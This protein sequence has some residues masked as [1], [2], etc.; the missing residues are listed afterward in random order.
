MP[1]GLRG[2]SS[3]EHASTGVDEE[4]GGAYTP[5]QDVAA[6]RVSFSQTRRDHGDPRLPPALTTAGDTCACAEPSL[7]CAADPL[8]EGISTRKPG[9]GVQ[10]L[11]RRQVSGDI[12]GAP[13]RPQLQGAAGGQCSSIKY[14]R[15]PCSGHVGK[16]LP[17]LE[18]L[19]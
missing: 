17:L 14:P 12:V 3:E 19:V 15:G 18:P 4:D 8:S 1:R 10:A 7:V 16:T 11:E 13:G 5:N 9:G 6:H 2:R